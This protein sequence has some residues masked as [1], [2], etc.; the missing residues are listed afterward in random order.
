MKILMVSSFLPYPLV[1]GGHV[2]LYNI[3]KKL[4]KKYEVSLICEKRDFQTEKDISEISKFCKKIITVP[5]KKQWTFSN[6]L[7]SVFSLD[8]FLIVGHTIPEMK[9]KIKEELK[10]ENYDL[11]H[12]ETSYVMQ[13]L[14]QSLLPIVLVEHNIEYLVYKKFVN[15]SLF[16]IRPFLNWDVL[17]LE[18]KEKDFWK[19]AKS[20]VAVSDK[21]KRIMN[22]D[23][24]VP[25]G[26]DTEKFKPK[27]TRDN[28]KRALF[29]GDF[30]WLENRDSARWI[31]KE[32]WPE[33]SS[34]V[35]SLKL[36]IVGKNIPDA[37]KRLGS[38][39]VVFEENASSDSSL[40]Y[41]N[42]F[43]LLAPIRIGGGT[44]F[45]ILESMACGIPVIT[46]SLGAEGITKGNE[47]IRADTVKEVEDAL[48]KLFNDERFY[49]N[50]SKSGRMLIENKFNWDNITKD[51]ETVYDKTLRK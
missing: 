13:N 36:W 4:S 16:F 23:F 6:I 19:K 29:I 30:K 50:I 35:K 11:I 27:T 25:N 28:E 48:L 17:K 20:L 37:I 40:I 45:K 22:A 18:K 38:A 21:E 14:P 34:K 44:S 33:V 12:V 31:L 15:R 32:I 3:L 1:N 5:R 51:L 46:T 9:K 7:K 26:V 10:K 41:N 49:E 43:V 2:R 42:S 8:P 24:V 39:N 47:I